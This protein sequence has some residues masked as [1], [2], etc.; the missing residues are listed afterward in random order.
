MRAFIQAVARVQG[1][2]LAPAEMLESYLADG[3]MHPEL[4]QVGNKNHYEDTSLAEG[5]GTP[6]LAV[7]FGSRK[8]GGDFLYGR[9]LVHYHQQG[10]INLLGLAFSRDQQQKEYVQLRL[11]QAGPT[12]VE[13][14]AHPASHLFIAGSAKRMP[15][16]VTDI[17]TEVCAR[18]HGGSDCGA[19]VHEPGSASPVHRSRCSL[20]TSAMSAVF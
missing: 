20:F 13:G 7:F 6:R 10:V 4:A 17:L 19:V 9:E 14:L 12:L 18:A 15:A 2:P 11:S 5:R 3:S 8:Q 1:V 16:D